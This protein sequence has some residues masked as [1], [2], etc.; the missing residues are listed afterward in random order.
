[1]TSRALATA[2]RRDAWL[3]IDLD[4][5]RHNVGVIRSLAGTAVIAPVVKADAY[6]HGS[7]RVV[8]ALADLVEAFCVATLD[9]ALAVRGQVEGRIISL[10]PVP[11]GAASEAVAADIELTVMSRADLDAIRAA[12]TA[13]GRRASVHLCLE[14]GMH[15]GGLEPSECLEVAAT[16]VADPHIAL[17]GLWSHI[18]SPEDA[19]AS[20]GQVARF[21]EATGA[22][23]GAG[24][25][26]PQ[27][28]L[29][30]SGSLFAR[31]APALELVRP[32][33][34][35]YGELDVGLP[36]ASAAQDAARDLRPAMALKARPIAVEELSVGERVGY[37]GRWQAERPSRI[38]ILPIGYGDGYVR[39]TQ[40]GATALVRG[41][42]VPL[43]GV[44]SMDALAVDVTDLPGIGPADEFALLGRQGAE[45]IAAGDL[46]RARNTI[47]WEV[48]ADM[49]A[50]LGRVYHP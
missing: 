14:T 12:A 13:L 11:A 29:A 44:I 19:S 7:A 30:A 26:V 49:A 9:E 35:V 6:G 3:E 23:A 5:I 34:A 22:L 18:A 28:H 41:R 32:G 48:L 27:R 4:A 40:P 33:L 50:R 43:V 25:V 39:G 10:Y 8:A 38:A 46:A 36:I 21:D 37:G 20:A 2:P 24:I 1:V 17:V 31:T 16:A 42:R 47:I 15:R 45:V